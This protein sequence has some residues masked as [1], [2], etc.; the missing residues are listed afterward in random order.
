MRVN[1]TTIVVDIDK[2]NKTDVIAE[3]FLFNSFRSRKIKSIV[4]NIFKYCMGTF[5][6][7]LKKGSNILCGI[8]L[9]DRSG[10]LFAR[11]W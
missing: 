9:L 5:V 7:Q 3:N 10:K 2:T 8:G 4:N 1:W 11:L 6:N